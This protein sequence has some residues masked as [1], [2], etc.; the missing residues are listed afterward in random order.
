MCARETDRQG[1]RER[2]ERKERK[3]EKGMWTK[4][5]EAIGRS[6]N[7]Q[8]PRG[9][10][11]ITQS[12]AFAV[13][14]YYRETSGIIDKRPSPLPRRRGSLRPGKCCTLIA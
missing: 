8:H 14:Y 11:R 2:R 5:T 1:G 3:R 13:R 7:V 6:H 10:P 9:Y 12:Y 4:E